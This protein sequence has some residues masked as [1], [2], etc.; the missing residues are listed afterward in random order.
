V[1]STNAEFQEGIVLRLAPHDAKFPCQLKQ[2]VPF[3]G[4]YGEPDHVHL[5]FE[6]TPV[7][8]LSK[9]INNLK[10]VSSRT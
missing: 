8:Q 3:R 4:T 7:V 5:L 10:T 9:L 2:A 6:A 1:Q